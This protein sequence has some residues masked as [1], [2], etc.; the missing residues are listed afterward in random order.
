MKTDALFYKLFRFDPRSL[1]RLVQLQIAGQYVFESITV[2]TTEK[3]FDGFLRPKDGDGPYIFLEIQGYDDPAIYWRLFREIA[4][5]YEASGSRTP[6]IA[7]VLFLDE[8]YD[9]GIPML[10]CTPPCQ[11]IR[12]NLADC[13]EAIGDKAGALTVLKPLTLSGKKEDQK[14]LQEL[15]PRWEEE[16]RSLKL[17]EH[18]TKEL[19]ELL[20]YTVLQRFPKLTLK[21]VQKMIQL[22]PLDQTV[23]AQELI[24]IAEKKGEKKGE[25]KRSKETARILLSMGKLT[26]KEI[27]RASGLSVKEVETLR[28]SQTK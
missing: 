24:Q 26:V 18:E 14:K 6:F 21:E 11:L 7:I 2:K 19:S 27:S 13:F 16:I 10:S 20:I 8:E 28:D 22:T 12:K 17:P 4:T 23:A 1:L 15:V 5:W 3:R 9:P 25:K